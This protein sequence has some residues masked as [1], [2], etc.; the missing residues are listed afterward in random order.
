MICIPAKEGNLSVF[1]DF[2]RMDFS[3]PCSVVLSA[4][5]WLNA[6]LLWITVTLLH[7]RLPASRKQCL[8]LVC[9]IRESKDG[10]KEVKHPEQRALCLIFFSQWLSQQL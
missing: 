9:V 1:D 3:D 5:L 4:E 2:S 6:S 10:L 8:P 7:L